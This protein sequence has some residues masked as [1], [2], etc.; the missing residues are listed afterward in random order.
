MLKAGKALT[1]LTAALVALAGCGGSGSDGKVLKLWHYESPDSA[2]GIAW[3]QA[4]DEFKKAHPGVKVEFEEKGFEQIQKTA[5]MVLKS[6][7]AP[8]VMEYNKGNATTGLLS[9]EGLLTDLTPQVTKY[10][11]D[12][13][14]SPNVAVTAKYDRRGVMGSGKWYGI[15]NYG[16][17]LTVYYNKDLFKKYGVPVPKNFAD[18]TAA[19]ATFKKHGVT[20]LTNAGAE[21]MAQQYLYQLALSKATPAW[22]NAYERYTGKVNFHDAAW[23]YAANTFADWVKKGYVAKD[24]VGLKSEEA[25]T[26]FIAGKYPMM[27]SGTWWYGRLENEVKKFD[28]GIFR[29]PA[30]K[31][32]IGSSGNVWVVPRGAKNPDLAYDFINLTM[33]K[34]V[35]NALGNNG[36]VPVAADPKAITDPKNRDLLA[37]YTALANGHAL[38]YYPDWPVPG[39]YDTLVADTQKLMN[40]SATP[41]AALGDLQKSYDAGVPVK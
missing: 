34:A 9:K 36:G 10:G 6:N 13:L 26:R 17:F 20:P 5:P 1:V 29:W 39:F 41:Y 24:S 22:V 18:F 4:M 38:A 14:L 40:G 23:T 32:T 2:M 33:R 30:S 7:D 12:K 3:K 16:E 31:L 25:G 19:L 35:Q 8:D 21:Y 15:P 37:Q 28:W 11:W 27:F